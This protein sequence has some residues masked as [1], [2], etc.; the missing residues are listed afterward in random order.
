MISYVKD[1]KSLSEQ[2]AIDMAR[3]RFTSDVSTLVIGLRDFL[4]LDLTIKIFGRVIWEWHFPPK[5]K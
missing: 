1:S 3:K 4:Q 2:G 5:S